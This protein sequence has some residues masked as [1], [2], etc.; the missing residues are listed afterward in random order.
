MDW[1]VRRRIAVGYIFSFVLLGLLA[2]VGIVALDQTGEAY[3]ETL[4]RERM[5]MQQGLRSDFEAR[6]AV[7]NHLRYLADPNSAYIERRDSLLDLSVS[8]FSLLADSAGTAA[9][10]ELWAGSLEALERWKR[11]SDRAID[12]RAAGNI[13]R[14]L[15][16]N[17]STAAPAFDVHEELVHRATDSLMAGSNAAMLAAQ[18][19]AARWMMWLAI[20]AGAALVISVVKS[21]LL[22]RA[23]SQPLGRTATALA[24]NSA[25]I[26]EATIEQAWAA[27]QAAQAATRAARRFED[28]SGTQVQTLKHVERMSDLSK[29]AAA[30]ANGGSERILH[31]LSDEAERIA[32]LTRHRIAELHD[33][34]EAVEEASRAAQHSAATTQQI[35][36]VARKMNAQGL[37]L[38]R[39]VFERKDGKRR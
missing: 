10:R 15:Q 6:G 39:L 22:N 26:L 3:Q 34:Q 36:S 18:R 7:L 16:I 19:E 4:R 8:T 33:I 30:S 17:G 28:T 31:S 24:S 11:A 38:L 14:A 5:Q 27:E 12:A 2:A 37:A 20:A 29:Q 9:T 13:Q 25:E 32:T 23:V 35:E 21:I 1:T